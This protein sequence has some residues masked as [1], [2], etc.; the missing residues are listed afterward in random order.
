MPWRS[1]AMS[2]TAVSPVKYGV[3]VPPT[4]GHP[5]DRR[6]AAEK[7]RAR[8][9]THIQITAR[10]LDDGG[11][12][13]FSPETGRRQDCEAA[14]GIRLQQIRRTGS[15]QGVRTRV[16]DD[17]AVRRALATPYG[18]ESTGPPAGLCCDSLAEMSVDGEAEP[19]RRHQEQRAEQPRL[20]R[21][22]RRAAQGRRPSPSPRTH[23]S[24]ENCT[25]TGPL[26]AANPPAAAM[27]GRL[28]S[29][30]RR[31]LLC[32]SGRCASVRRFRRSRPPPAGRRATRGSCRCR[33]C[34]PPATYKSP[35]GANPSPRGVVRVP[36]AMTSTDGASACAA[37]IDIAMASATRPRLIGFMSVISL[38]VS[39]VLSGLRSP[40]TPRSLCLIDSE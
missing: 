32:H 12:Y 2:T 8:Q 39:S 30:R 34:R 13:G 10:P 15:D 6:A 3:A 16:G 9:L 25:S 33:H 4:L 22:G 14:F 28:R 23:S 36:L 20:R 38:G 19:V 29:T 27:D 18:L 21:R 7:R 26:A 11:R 17:A 40:V 31:C 24:P 5:V 1:K 37:A 35:L